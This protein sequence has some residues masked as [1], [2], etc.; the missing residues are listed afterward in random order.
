VSIRV[1]DE[2]NLKGVKLCDK[3]EITSTGEVIISVK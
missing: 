3:A 2:K 1:E